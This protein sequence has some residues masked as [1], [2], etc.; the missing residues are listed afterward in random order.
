MAAAGV[1]HSLALADDAGL[2]KSVEN[3]ERGMNAGDGADL[4][5]VS[6]KD[7]ARRCLQLVG[8]ELGFG[9]GI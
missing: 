9:V 5:E 6:V 8:E 4:I 7:L 2:E 1:D 3:D